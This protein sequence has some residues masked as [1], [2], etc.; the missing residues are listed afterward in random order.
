M[1]VP[2][3]AQDTLHENMRYVCSTMREKVVHVSTS[4]NLLQL[5][6]T[7]V[8][9]HICVCTC[10][11]QVICII[12]YCLRN[13]NFCRNHDKLNIKGSSFVHFHLLTL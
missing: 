7:N 11:S 1:A 6:L 4:Q 5:Y 13:R 9:V 12:G 3:V 8:A 2:C 10:I